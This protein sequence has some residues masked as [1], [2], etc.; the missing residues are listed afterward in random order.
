MRMV[1]DRVLQRYVAKIRKFQRGMG[2]RSLISVDAEV[3][4]ADGW[5][6]S[7]CAGVHIG[8]VRRAVD[9][10]G[11]GG[12]RR[13]TTTLARTAAQVA[14]S[15]HRRRGER[16][17][18]LRAMA[19]TDPGAWAPLSLR[20]SLKGSCYDCCR[21]LAFTVADA[22]MVLRRVVYLVLAVPGWE[23]VSLIDA[24]A[25]GHPHAHVVLVLPRAQ[26]RFLYRRIVD[27][28]THVGIDAR[29]GICLDRSPKSTRQA[30]LVMAR[31]LAVDTPDLGWTYALDKVA[32]IK[33]LID[34]NGRPLGDDRLR[35]EAWRATHGVRHVAGAL[36]RGQVRLDR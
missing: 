12:A 4:D 6:E 16:V 13:R 10:F 34:R 29:G 20:F 18:A 11:S 27:A 1:S 2:D 31:T 7:A 23:A 8:N 30:W 35:L 36:R 3:A 33:T 25:Q 5:D 26:R 24:T 19:A 21:E 14:K 32:P 22:A 15:A 28:Y 17:E 9:L